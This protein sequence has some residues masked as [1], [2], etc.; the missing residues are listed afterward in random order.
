KGWEEG[1]AGHGRG[2][3][4]RAHRGRGKGAR[5]G[6][7]K[8]EQRETVRGGVSGDGVPRKRFAEGPRA[9]SRGPKSLRA[10]TPFLSRAGGPSSAEHP[11]RNDA[12]RNPAPKGTVRIG[13]RRNRFA[14]DFRATAFL[15]KRF[16]ERPRANS[17]G[18]KSLRAR[19]P[20]IS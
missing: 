12:L 14:N 7:R 1:G 8:G 11:V 4:A 9:N 2:R 16:A 13:V 6:K 15:E 17:H 20:F 10:R 19:T 5:G 18:S 3:G